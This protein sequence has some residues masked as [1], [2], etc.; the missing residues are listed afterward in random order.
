MDGF[1]TVGTIRQDRTRGCK[2]KSEK[3]LKK[4]GRVSYDGSVDLNSGIVIVR[5]F[6]NKAV[7]LI[8][9][10]IVIE[11][12]DK[13]ERR[14]K[15]AGKMITVSRPKIVKV[16]NSVMGGVNLFDMF[17]ALYRLDRK[18]RSWYMRIFEFLPHL[19]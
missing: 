9:K 4:E 17:Q 14:S 15:S 16:Y 10:Y 12:I 19:L 8:S 6:D 1:W 18:S 11:P 2:L 7:Q 3:E 5:W 13:V